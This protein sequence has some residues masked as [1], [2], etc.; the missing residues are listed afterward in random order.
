MN[1]PPEADSSHRKLLRA[2]VRFGGS[3]L[4]LAL[5]F[6]FLPV[7]QLGR[8]LERLP[9]HF[10]LLILAGYLAGHVIGVNKWRLMV[11][12][13]GSGLSFVQAVRCYFAGL[14]STLFLPSII[15]G[16]LV[17]VGLALRLGRSKAGVLL[18]SV[19][20]RILDVVALTALTAF[21]VGVVPGTLS[22]QNRWVFW[23]LGAAVLFLGAGLGILLAL[24][25]ARR[26]PYRMRRWFVMLRQAGRSTSRRP[27][28]VLLALVLAV[29]GQSGYVWLT[30]QIADAIGLHL[31]L[32]TWFFAWSLAKLSALLP[33]TQGGIGVREAALAA[34]LVPFGAPPV[35]SVAVG[36]AWEAIVICGG[37]IA[38][39]VSLLAGRILQK[40]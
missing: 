6:H 28:Y 40:R 26:F 25:P 23:V 11:N 13:A 14:F 17:R 32:R 29:A 27:E 5:L 21:G 4:V 24:L 3:I 39:L 36:L 16:D 34:L 9:A 18:G 33:V 37:L 7:A 30:S 38:G 10:W 20:D 35:L 2:V 22:P 1:S 8:T 15:G 12:L 19:L 31:T